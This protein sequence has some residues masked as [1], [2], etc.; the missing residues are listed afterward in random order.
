MSENP[1]DDPKQSVDPF[2]DEN[3]ASPPLLPPRPSFK[4]SI[5]IS[6]SAP[7]LPARPIHRQFES[8]SAISEKPEKKLV[9]TTT[10]LNRRY[11]ICDKFPKVDILQSLGKAKCSYIILTGLY[12]LTLTTQLKVFNL[13]TSENIASFNIQDT[14]IISINVKASRLEPTQ[15]WIGTER[16]ELL[17]LDFV[18][19]CKVDDR[20][21]VH[22]ASITHIINENFTMYTL[23]ENGGLKIW[24]KDST[25]TISLANRPRS[26]RIS[27]KITNL[28]IHED[29][30]WCSVGRCVEIYN[31]KE[32][33]I[34]VFIK[35]IELGFGNSNISCMTFLAEQN[36]VYT[37]H[38]DGKITVF[39]LKSETKKIVVNP[40]IYRIT[41][42][43]GVGKYLQFF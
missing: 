9:P 37:G 17:E 29:R 34:N 43:L 13:T 4:S 25:G 39:C 40:S 14:K 19:G 8:M 42:I 24:N 5:D 2:A 41:S 21:V 33:T 11:P 26:L 36:E 15:V 18:N 38:D 35:K 27:S 28:I 6:D 1:F 31:L 23:D 12:V 22:S 30:I 7:P 3:H 16:G 32:D 20:K 10:K